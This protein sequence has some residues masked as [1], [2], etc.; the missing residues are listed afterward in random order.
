MQSGDCDSCV[1]PSQENKVAKFLNGRPSNIK[2]NQIAVVLMALP[3][4]VAFK[5]CLNG[6]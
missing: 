6:A 5:S 3:N 4:F 1:L 2:A